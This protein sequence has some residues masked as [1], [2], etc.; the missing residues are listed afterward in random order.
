[1]SEHES[2]TATLHG[3]EIGATG[4]SVLQFVVETEAGSVTVRLTADEAPWLAHALQ[5]WATVSDSITDR[6]LS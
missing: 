1:M 6:P 3:L 4:P 2:L 5:H